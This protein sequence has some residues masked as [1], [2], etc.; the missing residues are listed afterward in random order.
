MGRLYEQIISCIGDSFD[1][2]YYRTQDGA[3][4]DLVIVQGNKP[5]YAI[6][7]KFTNAPKQT[8]GFLSAIGDIGTTENF[9]LVPEIRQPYPL[10]DKVV[11]QDLKGFL[12]LVKH[13]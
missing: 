4:A 2:Y 1:Y 7:I 12:G 8:K 11:V 13:D 3:E 9:I 5:R 10:S 6:E